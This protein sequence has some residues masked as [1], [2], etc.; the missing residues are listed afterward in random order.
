M[1][2]V[3]RDNE[4]AH[5]NILTENVSFMKAFLHQVNKHK[6]DLLKDI[7]LGAKFGLGVGTY[8]IHQA[9]NALNKVN[10]LSG[11]Y[12]SQEKLEMFDEVNR[13]AMDRMGKETDLSSGLE[14]FQ[15]AVMLRDTL[16][17]MEDYSA[18]TL[19]NISAMKYTMGVSNEEAVKYLDTLRSINGATIDQN[20]MLF[21]Q[22][23]LVSK[24]LNIS[25]TKLMDTMS[26]NMEYF[27]KYSGVGLKN[28]LKMA[29]ASQKLGV[30]MASM[31]NALEKLTSLDDI[32]NNQ[33]KMSIF[34][35]QRFDLMESAK[36]QFEGKS[37]KAMLALLE[38]LGKVEKSQFDSPYMRKVLSEG[39]GLSISDLVKFYDIAT[40]SD[41]MKQFNNEIELN[42]SIDNLNKQIKGLG[43]ER[44]T[45]IF[46]TQILNPLQTMFANFA[47]MIEFLI[48]IAG[49]IM[50]GVGG[51]ISGIGM[52][53]NSLYKFGEKFGEW[54]GSVV[55]GVLSLAGIVGTFTAWWRM[56][57]GNKTALLRGI[58]NN[59]AR[60][61]FGNS[62]NLQEGAMANFGFREK[63]VNGKKGKL[64]GKGKGA[65]GIMGLLGASVLSGTMTEDDI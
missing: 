38:Q 58:Y 60:I 4:N 8:L 11:G 59:T 27:A 31:T 17:K 32:I 57:D 9:T 50:K 6:F 51:I 10:D 42:K 20:T 65:L 2:N 34:L 26:D 18:R 62:A 28:M 3:Q 36:F 61:A 16:G 5:L 33:M 1:S 37:D 15:T 49:G 12:F 35:G 54:G 19:A 24:K 44:L 39:T 56:G 23:A 29:V 13:D 45:N 46:S 48:S 63:S 47:P 53:Y 43:F 40:D 21:Q 7:G 55:N 25:Y 41:K 14:Q 64:T 52:L 22:L 30:N